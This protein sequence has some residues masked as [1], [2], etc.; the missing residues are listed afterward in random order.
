MHDS[1]GEAGGTGGA[2]KPWARDAASGACTDLVWVQ[3]SFIGD[4]V[5]T[6][7]ALAL[8]ARALPGVRQHLVTTAIGKKAI[9]MHPA[10]ASCI[11]FEKRGATGARVGA[12]AAMRARGEGYGVRTLQG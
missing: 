9:G 6:T 10:L 8:A 12:V 11:V 4:V 3:T 2:T 7:A 1:A 5:L